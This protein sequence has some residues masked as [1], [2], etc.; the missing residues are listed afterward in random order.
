MAAAY[1][2]S[3]D[4]KSLLH[5]DVRFAPRTSFLDVGPTKHNQDDDCC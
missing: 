3:N 4:L 1:G 2:L 5:T